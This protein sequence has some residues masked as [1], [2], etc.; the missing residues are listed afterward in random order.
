MD[1]LT[2]AGVRPLLDLQRVDSAIDRLDQRKAD[3]PEQ[4]ELDQLAG[5]RTTTGGEHAEKRAELDTVVREQSKIED[6]VTTV[7]AKIEHEEKRLYSGE[8]NNAKELSNIQ[9]ELD[10]LRRRKAHLEDQ[11]L[12]VMERREVLEQEAGALATALA[13][14]DASVADATARRDVAVAEIERELIELRGHRDVLVPQIPADAV[15]LYETVRAK[16]GGVAVGAYEA[17]TCRACGLP[18]S[19][20]AKEEIKSGDDPLPRCENCRRILIPV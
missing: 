19:P 17:G 11:E 7:Q 4:R 9:A 5:E 16:F 2:R 10:A 13:Q 3:L 20:V 15:E 12:E 6:D 8:V 1:E 14:L 18:L